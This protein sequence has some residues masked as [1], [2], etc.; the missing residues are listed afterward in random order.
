MTNYTAIKLNREEFKYTKKYELVNQGKISG[1]FGGYLFN[2]LVIIN[3]TSRESQ[4]CFS[5]ENC[6]SAAMHVIRFFERSSEFGSLAICM[7]IYPHLAQPYHTHPCCSCTTFESDKHSFDAYLLTRAPLAEFQ[8]VQHLLST[9][10]S[11]SPACMNGAG[12]Y[13]ALCQ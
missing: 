2:I 1:L 7:Q 11:Q 8:Y 3:E 9:G 10:S 4:F 5:S 6:L 13:P 12:H